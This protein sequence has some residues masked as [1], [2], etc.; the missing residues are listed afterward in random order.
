MTSAEIDAFS[1][2]CRQP[3]QRTAESG[4]CRSGHRREAE[5]REVIKVK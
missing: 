5:I 2:K 4:Y 1:E 3:D